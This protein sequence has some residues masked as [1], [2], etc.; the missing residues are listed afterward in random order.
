MSHAKYGPHPLKTVAVHKEQRN[1]QMDRLSFIYIRCMSL[2]AV[3]PVVMALHTST[4]LF[5]V[6]PS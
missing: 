4:T 2:A 3:W 6:R 5:C 1:R